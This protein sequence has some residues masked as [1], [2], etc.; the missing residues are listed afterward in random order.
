MPSVC[1][2]YWYDHSMVLGL[3][4]FSINGVGSENRV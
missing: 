2:S 1:V 3:D 4:L